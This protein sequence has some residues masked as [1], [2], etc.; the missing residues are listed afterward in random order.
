MFSTQVPLELQDGLPEALV[1]FPDQTGLEV[2]LSFGCDYELPFLHGWSCRTGPRASKAFI[3][4][5]NQ[6]DMPAKLPGQMRPPSWLCRH[7][8]TDQVLHSSAAGRAA[9]RATE[10]PRRSGLISCFAG[11]ETKSNSGQSYGLASLPWAGG[12]LHT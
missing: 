3:S 7:R 1:R 8:A 12:G 9:A 10:T 2:G 4:Q 6:T 11:L 5:S